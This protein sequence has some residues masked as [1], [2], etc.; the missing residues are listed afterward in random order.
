MHTFNCV[1]CSHQTRPTA[2]KN[3]AA[4]YP[5]CFSDHL[6]QSCSLLAT[7]ASPCSLPATLPPTHRLLRPH[8]QLARTRRAV[9]SRHWLMGGRARPC[10]TVGTAPNKEKEQEVWQEPTAKVR[11]RITSIIKKGSRAL[12]QD[13]KSECTQ[14]KRHRFGLLPIS[15]LLIDP[16]V[17]WRQAAQILQA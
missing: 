7:P 6:S 11:A 5:A 12:G 14:E 17:C 3:S 10:S 4:H 13:G 16:A 15:A 9:R 2:P 1:K 8:P